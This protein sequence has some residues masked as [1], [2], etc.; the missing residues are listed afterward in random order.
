V[1][2]LI[3]FT[4]VYAYFVRAICAMLLTVIYLCAV[5]KSSLERALYLLF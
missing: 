2:D 4:I 3:Y 5:S 1:L